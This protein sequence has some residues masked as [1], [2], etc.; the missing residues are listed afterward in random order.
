MPTLNIDDEN[1]LEPKEEFG[2]RRRGQKRLFE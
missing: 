1:P 2:D